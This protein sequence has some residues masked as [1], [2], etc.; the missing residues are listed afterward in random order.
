MPYAVTLN[1]PHAYQR[2]HR[3]IDNA[4]PGYTVRVEAPRRTLD[5]NAKLWAVL[6]DIACAM[7]EGRRHDPETW[8]AIFM[9]A[10]GHEQ[11]FAMGLNGE[12]FPLGYRSS[13]MRKAQFSE[14]IEFI[15]SEVARRGW[16]V[17][18]TDHQ[19]DTA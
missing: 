3:L 5:Q 11:R 17:V 7:P 4:P 16:P 19:E 12:P 8:K 18:W 13:K 1:G 15:Y 14:F 2:A 10:F 6:T 9:Q